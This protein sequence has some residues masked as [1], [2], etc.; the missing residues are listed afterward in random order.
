MPV[1]EMF[2]THNL[3]VAFNCWDKTLVISEMA[4]R[5][6]SQCL[7]LRAKNPYRPVTLIGFSMGA[8]AIVEA[9]DMPKEGGR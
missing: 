9:V 5:V 1:L 7:E 4:S 3:E 8:A 2:E 6:A